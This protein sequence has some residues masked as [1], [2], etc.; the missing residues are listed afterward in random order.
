MYKGRYDL[1]VR[2]YP[3]LCRYCHKPLI[4]Y[5]ALREHTFKHIETKDI[6]LVGQNVEDLK[7]LERID[8]EGDTFVEET[9][10]EG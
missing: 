3:Y 10:S 7:L 6:C 2:K 5:Q 8:V 4:N 1:K 9:I